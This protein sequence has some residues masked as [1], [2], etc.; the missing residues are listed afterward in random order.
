M[1]LFLKWL[2]IAQRS[3]ALQVRIAAKRTK[4]HTTTTMICEEARS[5]IYGF[6]SIYQQKKLDFCL[7]YFLYDLYWIYPIKLNTCQKQNIPAHQSA[8]MHICK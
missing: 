4:E 5:Q 8:E 3:P 6:F 2:N 1:E 7:M